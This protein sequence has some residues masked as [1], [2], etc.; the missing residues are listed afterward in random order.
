MSDTFDLDEAVQ[1][2]DVHCWREGNLLKLRQGTAFP[3]HGCAKCGKPASSPA[4]KEILQWRPRWLNILGVSV[5]A[6]LFAS[7]FLAREDGDFS[8]LSFLWIF[9][10]A[11]LIAILFTR[12]AAVQL[13]LCVYHKR[14]EQAYQ[15][16]SGA[17]SFA[18][19]CF[20]FFANHSLSWS[21]PVLWGIVTIAVLFMF[22]LSTFSITKIDKDF[23]W[24]KGCGEAFLAP[25]PSAPTTSD[26]DSATD[27][28]DAAQ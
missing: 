24:I 20:A 10:A 26:G 28:S 4:Q 22:L 3:D 14:R 5:V 21:R 23:V 17:L 25:L 8:G 7:S 1:K 12:N 18:V 2:P 11:I 13:S 27:A 19:I 16:I 15:W 6:L 9:F